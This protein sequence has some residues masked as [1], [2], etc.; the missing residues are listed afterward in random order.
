V[1]PVTSSGAATLQSFQPVEGSGPEG[2]KRVKHVRPSHG[3]PLN[4][5]V[6]ETLATGLVAGV[7]TVLDLTAISLE[8]AC[9]ITT[10]T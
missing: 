1:A 2:V 5:A 10:M 4:Q 3:P 9:A 7:I 6:G 8:S